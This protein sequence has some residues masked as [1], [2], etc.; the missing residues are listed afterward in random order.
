[1]DC[2]ADAPRIERVS[3][4]FQT[5]RRAWKTNLPTYGEVSYEDVYPGVDLIYYG[6]EV[7]A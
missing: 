5:A 6:P 1:M 4:R 3:S 7:R 2:A